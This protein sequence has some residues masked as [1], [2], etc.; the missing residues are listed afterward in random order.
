MPAG[1][2]ICRI[3]NAAIPTETGEI[4]VRIYHPFAKPSGLMVYYHGGGWTLGTIEAYDLTIQRL[5]LKTGCTI[6]SVGY[7]LAPEHPFPAAVDDALSAVR[8]TSQRTVE[9]AGKA[10]PLIVAGDSAG[11]NLA[12]VVSQLV[13]DEGGAEIAAQILLYPATDGKID[14]EFMTRFES[15]FLTKAE[16]AWFY[17]QYIPDRSQRTDPRFAPLH[18]PKLGN[19]PPALVLTAECDLLCEEGELYARRLQEAGVTVRQKRYLGTFHGFFSMDRGLLPYSGQAMDDIAA[20]L[21]DVL[22]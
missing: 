22:R 6:V 1:P 13:R 2:D 16:I 18:A 17:D 15:P 11:G 19:L 20:F 14:S 3:E 9:L 21:S 12:A 7:R 4:P 10:V 5:T 8:W